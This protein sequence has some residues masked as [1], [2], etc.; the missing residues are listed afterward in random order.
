[1]YIALNHYFPDIRVHSGGQQYESDKKIVYD[2][3][4]M[5]ILFALSSDSYVIIIYHIIL[6]KEI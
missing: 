2:N 6:K 5:T 1:V 3:F 4:M